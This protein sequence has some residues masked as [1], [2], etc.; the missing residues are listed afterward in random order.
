MI[1]IY[2]LYIAL[3]FSIYYKFYSIL[4]YVPKSTIKA[5]KMLKQTKYLAAALLLGNNKVDAASPPTDGKF[6]YADYE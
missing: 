2:W 3:L 5:T 4:Y 6:F 1:L